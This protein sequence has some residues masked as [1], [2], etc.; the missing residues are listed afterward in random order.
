MENENLDAAQMLNLLYVSFKAL[1]NKSIPNELVRF[2]YEIRMISAIGE[3][4]DFFHM[5]WLRFTG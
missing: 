5:P 4:S 2:I 1:T 3:C